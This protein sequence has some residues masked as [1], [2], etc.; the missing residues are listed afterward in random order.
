L[1]KIKLFYRVLLITFFIGIRYFVSAQQ[2]PVQKFT[3]E[4]G[5]SNANV[6]RILEDSLGFLWFGTEYGLSKY[7]GNRFVNYYSVN[8]SSVT[9]IIGISELSGNKKLICTYKGIISILNNDSIEQQVIKANYDY[10]NCIHIVANDKFTW[11][12]N[13]AGS[14]FSIKDR[15][16]HRINFKDEAG[17]DVLFQTII[18][19]SKNSILCATNKGLFTFQDGKFTRLLGDEI[20][21]NVYTIFKDKQ[22]YLWIGAHNKVYKTREG[23]VIEAYNIGNT[24]E[25]SDLIVDKRGRCW[26][27]V[28]KKGLMMIEDGV[29]HNLT[30]RINLSDILI[31]TLRED[32]NGDIWIG[33]HGSGLFCLKSTDIINYP[34]KDGTVNNYVSAILNDHGKIYVGSIGTISIY[35][36]SKLTRLK[37]KNLKAVDYVYFL[38]KVNG[39]L[40]IGTPAALIAKN[41]NYPYD[42][43]TILPQGALCC[44]VDKKNRTWVGKYSGAGMPGNRMLVN[45][46]RRTN[47][48]TPDN[49]GNMYFG[50]DSGV[51]I[52]D[53]ISFQCR[54]LYIFPST[55][56]NSIFRDHLN[57]MWIATDEGLYTAFLN[58]IVHYNNKSGLSSNNCTALAEDKQ[59]NMWIATLSGLNK[60]SN[61]H[62]SWIDSKSGICSDAVL[63]LCLDDSQNL[64]VGTINGVSILSNKEINSIISSPPVYITNARAGKTFLYFPRS[65][66]LFPRDRF[67]HI[68]YSGLEY[69]KSDKVEFQYKIEPF[70][71]Q[72]H[73][74]TGNE[75]E[76]SALPPGSYLFILRARHTGY[77]WNTNTATL[78]IKVIAPIWAR[79]DFIVL[80]IGILMFLIY[81]F[82]RYLILSR[83]H[84]RRREINLQHKM[85]S[86][87]QQ[88][89]N[90]SI[91]PHF[92]FNCLNTIQ[93]Y[94]YANDKEMAN[95]FLIIFSRLIR[96]TLEHSEDVFINFGKEM[97][98]I[99][100]FL[101]IEQMRF[102]NKLLYKI[103]I[104][105]AI[106]VNSIYIPN[107]I[108]QPYIE[109]AVKHGIMPKADG[110]KITIIVKMATPD[111]LYVIIEDNGIG[112]SK[113]IHKNNSSHHSMGMKLTSER[114]DLMSQ[115]HQKIFEVNVAEVINK[116]LE[117]I[118]TRVEL[119]I[120]LNIEEQVT[121]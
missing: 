96:T 75:I 8:G 104:D 42:E 62:F 45:E 93:S 74:T 14:L 113:S 61:G 88:A 49:M 22:S 25:I 17:K 21:E 71:K 119:K 50:T 59:G 109:N 5:L 12:V 47:C 53:P 33:T 37:V 86:L 66:T 103:E 121:V 43:K 120:A 65:I 116:N 58:R 57:T 70:D 51:Y 32:K 105:K 24:T 1:Y 3:E 115:L 4:N 69:P 84:A 6:Y 89:L 73:S 99:E 111:L 85:I 108:L 68:S 41:V 27:A 95:R 23:K 101:T 94:I 118:G 38:K 77:E 16:G 72:W 10:S 9:G 117:V 39:Y 60:L 36:G 44:H 30:S 54:K 29:L 18:Y 2:Y 28:P 15:I 56:I 114:L 31:N 81:R 83:E 112:L 11:I 79:T 92:V 35:N 102:Q 90:A 63:S 87:R 48:I 67:L 40:F 100:L 78:S 76:L 82:F 20:H 80:S 98:R 55:R 107:M 13:K 26:I 52:V 34:I 91:N 64:L 19:N 46:N 110:G 7:D 97:D 106:D